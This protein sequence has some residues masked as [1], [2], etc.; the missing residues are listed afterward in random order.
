M[1]KEVR[2]WIRIQGI[3]CS[4]LTV[5]TGLT[6]KWLT[7]DSVTALA[8]QQYLKGNSVLEDAIHTVSQRPFYDAIPPKPESMDFRNQ[9]EEARMVPL[10]STPSNLLADFCLPFC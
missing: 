10:T 1:A 3:S 9:E 5:L 8:E 7:K 4:D 2:Q 6:E